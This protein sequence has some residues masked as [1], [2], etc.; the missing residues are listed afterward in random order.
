MLGILRRPGR[1]GS[2]RLVV[3]GVKVQVIS[4][5]CMF[6]QRHRHLVYPTQTITVP[7][8]PWGMKM[9]NSGDAQHG[10]ETPAVQ[11]GPSLSH[12]TAHEI[13]YA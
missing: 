4:L 2:P 13:C 7:Q 12:Y 10:K 3:L 5:L 1:L 6:Q 9:E 8:T 11:V